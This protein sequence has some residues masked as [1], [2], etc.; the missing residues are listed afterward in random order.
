MK[1]TDVMFMAGIALIIYA[2]F[3]VSAIL[4]LAVIGVILNRRF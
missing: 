4:G 1:I 3:Q 2:A